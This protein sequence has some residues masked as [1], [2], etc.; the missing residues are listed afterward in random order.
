MTVGIV[1]SQ[2]TPKTKIFLY[3][4]VPI[5][6][7]N[8][9][10]WGCFSNK[11]EQKEFFDSNY[12]HT[13]L[14]DYSYQRRDGTVN[15]EGDYD[16]FRNYNYMVYHNGETGNR[17]RWV[18]CFITSVGYVSDYVT[19]ISFETD[20]IQT[21][22]FEI[23]VNF[24]D[25]FIA[26]EHRPRWWMDGSEKRPCINTQPENME[27]GTD[28][29]VISAGVLG[30]LGNDHV[31]YAIVC[32]TS[33][34][35]GADSSASFVCGAPSQFSYYIFPFDVSNGTGFIKNPTTVEL[36]NGSTFQVCTMKTFYDA[37]RSDSNLVNKCVGIT[38]TQSLPYATVDDSGVVHFKTSQYQKIT[39]SGLGNFVQ[40]QGGR[41]NDLRFKTDVNNWETTQEIDIPSVY[42]S[43][44]ET[45]L[46]WYP[47]SYMEVMDNNGTIKAYKNEYWLGLK[48]QF[49]L[50]GA[51]DS[52][53]V[54]YIP[55][56]YKINS[57]SNN[58][59][60]NDLE[61]FQTGYE[62]SLPVVSDY[63]AALMQSSQN[64]MNAN[65]SNTIRSNETSLR[66]A[67][68]TNAAANSQAELQNAVS[69]TTTRNNNLLNTKLTNLQITAN[70]EYARIQSA[71]SGISGVLSA[72]G[73][74]IGGAVG[75]STNMIVGA[76]NFE[77]S[78]ITQAR[79][80]SLQNQL[81]TANNSVQTQANT[82]STHIAN[83]LRATTT[84][85]QAET[86]IQNA[87]A[88]YTA[89]INDAIASAD[90]IVSGGSNPLRTFG[91]GFTSVTY[92][93]YKPAR[94]Y[95]EILQKVFKVRGYAT[96]RYKKPYLHTR[97]NWNYIQTVKCNIIDK[98][99]EAQDIEKIKTA[100]DNGI[101]LWHNKDVGDYSKSNNEIED[102]SKFNQWGDYK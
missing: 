36:S 101:T 94:E 69:T 64:S 79:S 62:M 21:Y 57:K 3:K 47:F 27:Q 78:S 40:C 59:L 97:E 88:S 43:I 86:N 90:S 46:Y 32:M 20:V 48:A 7:M 70:A 23:E 9:T 2:F 30:G 89:Q 91:N 49:G 8:N 71:Q 6:A 53:K 25:S 44:E 68:A 73:G 17:A 16:D 75:A 35:T 63:T 82:A 1:N 34:T 10:F 93:F 26:Y 4:E 99:I 50:A 33:D 66:I 45:K 11:E 76:K 55:L 80:A 87:M 65:V 31:L 95:L 96:N 5:D 81:A 41:F 98:D 85:Y 29:E 52:S 37:I 92:R 60:M 39:N 24:K 15:I 102:F 100:F 28:M 38:V 84:Q 22:R 77:V 61:A 18:Y 54:D 12:E 83:A 67:S 72:V 42:S 56:D 19:S 74:D 14:N 58:F 51:I 13:T